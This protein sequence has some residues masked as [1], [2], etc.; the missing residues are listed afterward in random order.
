MWNHDIARVEI[1]PDAADRSD[2][3]DAGGTTFPERPEIGAVIH[4]VRRNG[5]PIPVA[6][7]KSDRPATNL[8]KR[9]GTG[10]IAKRRAYNFTM[11]NIKIGQLRKSTPSND[12]QHVIDPS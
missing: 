7:Q 12:R 11:R 4:L 9:H 6:R 10:R 8:T 1:G 2:R 3:N 5:V